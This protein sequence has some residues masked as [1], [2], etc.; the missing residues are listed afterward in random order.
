[1]NLATIDRPQSRKALGKLDGNKGLNKKEDIGITLA[2]A[3]KKR[4]GNIQ[5]YDSPA[6]GVPDTPGKGGAATPG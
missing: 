3:L 5:R 1:M 2:N 4:F 6:K